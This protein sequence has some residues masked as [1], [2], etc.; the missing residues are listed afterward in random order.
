MFLPSFQLWSLFDKLQTLRVVFVAPDAREALNAAVGSWVTIGCHE[1]SRG[2]PHGPTAPRGGPFSVAIQGTVP[3][4]STAPR[5]SPGEIFR[6]SKPNQSRISRSSASEI[7]LPNLRA[8]DHIGVIHD[9]LWIRCILHHS[10]N[11]VK[12]QNSSSKSSNKTNR[13][14]VN[15]G[16][17]R[18]TTVC[19]LLTSVDTL[20]SHK[21]QQ[22]IAGCS[23]D[24]NGS[25]LLVLELTLQ[26]GH[27]ARAAPVAFAT[28]PDKKMQKVERGNK[29]I[30]NQALNAGRRLRNFGI[31]Q[32]FYFFF[33]L[34]SNH[35]QPLSKSHMSQQFTTFH[36]VPA[37]TSLRHW[38]WSWP[39]ELFTGWVVEV[40]RVET[41]PS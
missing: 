35:S 27:T 5:A 11:N 33:H 19:F 2:V 18:S 41:G 17:L 24:Q 38:S 1:R 8:W 16:Q 20:F 32:I 10:R 3:S 6:E 12:Q 28:T 26:A 40:P 23:T 34:I 31:L 15:Y 13:K 22:L 30:P 21:L 36:K 4:V 37:K 7:L 29:H 14:K 25:S 39:H 9:T